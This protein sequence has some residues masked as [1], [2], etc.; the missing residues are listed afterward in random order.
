MDTGATLQALV[1]SEVM[2]K[3]TAQLAIQEA[4]RGNPLPN[5]VLPFFKS[6][7][8]SLLQRGG[9]ENDKSERISA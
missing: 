7:L 2:S 9:N 8:Q 3:R 5:I 4:G 6:V 1:I